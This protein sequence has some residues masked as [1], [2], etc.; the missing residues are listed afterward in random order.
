MTRQ[1]ETALYLAKVT[2]DPLAAVRFLSR[3]W[4]DRA[5]ALACAVAV[6]IVKSYG[7]I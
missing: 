1:I 2:G 7:V 5:V 3:C 6:L 4:A